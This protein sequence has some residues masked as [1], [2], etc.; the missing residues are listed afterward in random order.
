M[1][2]NI[3]DLAKDSRLSKYCWRAWIRKREIES[4]RL[5]R[6]VLVDEQVYRKFIEARRQPAMAKRFTG[7]PQAAVGSY[8]V[9]GGANPLKR[10]GSGRGA[11][12]RTYPD[13]L[14]A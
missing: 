7:G 10:D 1:L 4:V 8:R 13:G 12:A 5:G 9:E 11:P 6:R 3:D 14:G 2:M